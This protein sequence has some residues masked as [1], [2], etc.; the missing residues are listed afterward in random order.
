MHMKL[1]DIC[2]TILSLLDIYPLFFLDTVKTNMKIPESEKGCLH[3]TTL[4]WHDK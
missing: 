4:V 1:G 2:F 3:I